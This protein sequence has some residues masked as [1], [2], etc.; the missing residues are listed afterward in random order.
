MVVDEHII[1]SGGLAITVSGT[2]ISFGSDTVPFGSFTEDGT[3][4]QHCI[5]FWSYIGEHFGTQFFTGIC[6]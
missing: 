4:C 1:V 3:I 6:V 5:G 2:G